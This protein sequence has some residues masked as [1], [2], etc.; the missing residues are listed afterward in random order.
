MNCRNHPA[1][2]AD[3][4]CAKCGANLC[5]VCAYLQPENTSLCLE[6]YKDVILNKR[7][8]PP[9]H[10]P[11]GAMCSNHPTVP[12]VQICQLCQSPICKICDFEFPNN[13]HVCPNCVNKPTK[14]SQKCQRNLVWSYILAALGTFG[15]FLNMYFY[16]Q[17]AP[18]LSEHVYGIFFMAIILGP[19]ITGL[20]LATSAKIPNRKTPLNILIS[21]I[22]NSLL[23]GIFFILVIVGQLRN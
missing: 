21:M 11:E 2:E 16:W 7:T 5:K 20:S 12:A 6:C 14:P 10:I 22:W 23:I 18:A 1:V 13:V 15:Y 4:K 17:I 3:Y 9:L 8:H 19:S